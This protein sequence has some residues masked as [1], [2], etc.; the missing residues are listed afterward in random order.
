LTIQHSVTLTNLTKETTYYYKV[1]SK[2]AANNQTIDDNS[3]TGW[4]FTTTKTPGEIIYVGGGGGRINI[5]SI[6]PVISD[7]LVSEITSNTAK[8]FWKTNENAN[9]LVEYGLSE[10]Y[11]YLIGNHEQRVYEHSAQILEL[12][13]GTE[14]H[15]RVIS[16]DASGNKG[17]SKDLKFKTLEI[18]QVPIQVPGQEVLE[19]PI[20]TSEKAKAVF[21]KVE[22]FG[23]MEM[24][25]AASQTFIDEILQALPHNPYI[26]EID[27][28]KFLASIAEIAPKIVSAPLIAGEYPLVESGA[29]YAKI[30]WVTDKQ[31]N[32]IVALA[33]ADEY[34]ITKQE[35]YVLEFG[36][37]EELITYHEVKI[38]GLQSNTLYHF[39]ARS[40]AQLGDWAKSGDRTFTT[41][42]HLP[43]ISEIKFLKIEENT[44]TLSWQTSLPTKTK[45]KILDSKTGE[46]IIQEDPSYLKNHTITI[47]DLK[48]GTSYSLQ[49]FTEDEKGNTSFSSILPF[50]TSIS[51]KPPVISQVR[52]NAALIPGKIERV[53]TIISWQTDKPATSR[54]FYE[55]GI[56]SKQELVLSVPLNS[57]L[58]LDHIVI[59]TVF[60]PGQIYRFR[61]ESADGFNNTSYSQDFTI[62]TPRSRESIIDLI[63]Q[64]FEQTFGFLNFLHF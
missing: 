16:Y 3:G 22:D 40:K 25:Q 24:I 63:I 38:T 10:K 4:T 18:G 34:D 12:D 19:V 50:S 23:I 15:F 20:E 44:A 14:Y 21:A 48:L 52:I 55:Q 9:G 37:S 2:D 11:G 61:I 46:E 8:I 39:E 42:S 60:K 6:P 43:E 7:I 47:K 5:D 13:S 27:E 32:S 28:K 33:K 45:I 49:I 31:A 56:S 29:D 17:L 51:L 26:E 35:P 62:L 57:D 30:T 59:I 54:I 58:V 41:L 53:Q 1:I 64:N 36:N